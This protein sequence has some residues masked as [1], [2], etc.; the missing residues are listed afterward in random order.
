MHSKNRGKGNLA[1]CRSLTSK[2]THVPYELTQC[3]LPPDRGDIPAFI[4]QLKLV[5]DLA[6]PQGF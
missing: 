4:Q 2:G 1:T 5:L 3:Y 6:T